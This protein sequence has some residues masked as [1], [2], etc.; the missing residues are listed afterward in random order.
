MLWRG[1]GQL[2]LLL[3]PILSDDALLRRGRKIEP[4][5]ERSLQRKLQQAR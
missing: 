3:A 5:M 4:I 2:C 1:F